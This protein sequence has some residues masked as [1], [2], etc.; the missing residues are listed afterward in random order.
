[1]SGS[2]IIA[3]VTTALAQQI[4]TA[5][6]AEY[7]G[8]DVLT[9]RPDAAVLA[10]PRV[11]LF[12]YQASPNPGLR[13]D[14]L[15][16]RSGGSLV[17]RPTVALDLHYL[18]AFYGDETKLEPQKLLGAA[19]SSLHSHPLLP[20]S[21]LPDA[22]ERVRFTPHALSL[23][24]LSKLWS[25]FFQT[26]Y[27]LSVAYQGSVVLIESGETPARALP[28][29]QRG[30]GDTGPSALPGL[31][32]VFPLLDGLYIG[33]PAA[34]VLEPRP[35]SCPAA[36]LGHRL[37]FSGG[38]L[39]GDSVEIVFSHTKLPLSKTLKVDPAD[40]ADTEIAV[41]LPND[42]AAATEWAAGFYTACAKVTRGSEVRISNRWSFALAPQIKAIAPPSPIARVAGTATLTVTPYPVVPLDQG[43]DLLLGD[44][45]IAAEV[46]AAAADPL[47]FVIDE[48]PVVKDAVL[49]LR[50]EGVD[51]LPYFLDTAVTPARMAFD[52]GQKVS[53][54]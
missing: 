34:L 31:D 2:A 32:S 27:A 43:A 1:M 4:R 52:P 22:V 37:A 26:P 24:E 15:P 6:Q 53:I 20:K 35:H 40:L 23:D 47:V 39:A 10:G 28:V 38:N 19:A 18:L 51:S 14:D 11:R 50:I 30:Q 42:A 29:L 7:P 13:N 36:Q 44:R 8:A 12:L 21:S 41:T 16:T 45:G 9:T 54:A 5:I 17:A 3:D 46:R 48:A 25:V 33:E 49:R